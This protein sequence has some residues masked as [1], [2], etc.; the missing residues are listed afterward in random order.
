MKI[1]VNYLEMEFFDRLICLTLSPPSYPLDLPEDQSIGEPW[2]Q[3]RVG[4][5]G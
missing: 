1:D 3:Q 5:S 2:F 4:N